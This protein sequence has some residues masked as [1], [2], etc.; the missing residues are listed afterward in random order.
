MVVC[1]I[2]NYINLKTKK[3]EK[4]ELKKNQ[5]RDLKSL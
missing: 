1:N 5:V 3:N 4:H 2:I